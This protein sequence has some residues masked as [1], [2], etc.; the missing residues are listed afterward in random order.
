MVKSELPVWL[1]LTLL[2]ITLKADAVQIQ[3]VP[4]IELQNDDL[5]Y[6]QQFIHSLVSFNNYLATSYNLVHLLDET[7]II[8]NIVVVVVAVLVFL[9]F[10]VVVVVIEAKCQLSVQKVNETK[11]MNQP[12][13]IS[14]ANGVLMVCTFT[15][16]FAC[17][18]QPN[19][20]TN[21]HH[22]EVHRKLLFAAAAVVLGL[23]TKRAFVGP[24]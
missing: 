13:D 7:I 21:L 10:L 15:L 9:V 6:L 18:N 1:D 3:L 17:E 20:W 8:I 16:T 2:Y 24:N 19:R 11:S 5:V 14:V 12:V 23:Q 4:F 22:W